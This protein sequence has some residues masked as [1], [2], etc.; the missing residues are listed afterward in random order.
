MDTKNRV[1]VMITGFAMATVIIGAVF[2]VMPPVIV[3]AVS[4]GDNFNHIGAGL[5][6]TVL[7][8]QNVKFNGTG[9][10]NA[11]SDPSKVKV[12]KFDKGHWY[13]YA[14]P[15][16]DGKAYN[17]DWG[18]WLTLRATDGAINTPL[19]VKNPY[20]PLKLKVKDKVV[21]SIA[22]GTANFW[23]DVSGINLLPEDRVDLVIIGPDGQIK[24]DS[25][26]NQI[27]TNITV[28]YLKQT[29]GNKSAGLNTAGWVIGDYTFQVKTKPEYTCGLDARSVQ[30][31]LKI[32][33]GEISIGADKTSCIENE[34]VR[35]TVKGVP[36]DS[37]TVSGPGSDVSFMD[38]VYDTPAS[39]SG[40]WIDRYYRFSDTIDEDGTRTYAVKFTDTGSYTIRVDVTSGA[41]KG[42]YDTADISVSE[43]A[44]VFDVPATV[45][46]GQKFTI[47]GHVNAGHFVTIAVED[48]VYNKL[49]HLVIDE[50][51]E[52]SQDIDTAADDIP[53]FKVP[54][55]VTLKAYIDR[56]KA[57]SYPDSIR[58]GERDDGST[59][60]LLTRGEL[61]A[62][63][64]ADNISRGDDF[65]ITGEA[66]GT[67]QV[68]I[69]II[70]PKGSSGSIIT[71]S[72][73]DRLVITQPDGTP[74]VETNI[75][76]ASVSVS[77]TD[78]TF[79]KKINVGA[80]A[81]NGSYL[82]IVLS[83]GSDNRYGKA[84]YDSIER[85]LG[86]YT[87]SGK[88]QD[89]VLA[90]VQDA[91]VG[92]VGSGDLMW[93]TYVRVGT[94]TVTLNPIATVT[95]GEPLVVTGT[96]N[97]GDGHT[98]II[99]VK[100]P[101]TVELTPQ[102]VRVE[103]GTFEATFD[104]T[105]AVAGI[106]TVI[107]DDGDGHTDEATVKILPAI[108]P[109]SIRLYKKWNF[110]SVPKKLAEGHNTFEQV[111]GSVDTAGH[112]IF[113]YNTTEGWRAV[114]A[115][116]EV[117]PL[118]GYWIYSAEDTIVNLTYDTY[119]LRTPPTRQLYK[120]W[121]A[122]GFSDTTPAAANSAL[123]SIERSWAY[124]IGFDAAKQGYESVII[125]DDETGG[126][127]DED[128][129]MYPMK[130]YWIY[131]TEDSELVGISV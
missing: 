6:E 16:T 88:T 68:D 41:R 69:L 126:S 72:S 7:E 15:W 92:A 103:N 48:K 46:I 102:L 110:I 96:S 124:L 91:T 120:G 58:S 27:F 21:T 18:T 45:V 74:I 113:Y 19:S 51:G 67:K 125:N 87:L 66:K 75:Y 31:S 23:L 55:S 83:P 94:P 1:K 5:Y 79:T 63:V 61:T 54:G 59:A 49:D 85:A 56:P 42:D 39:D 28:S 57:Y 77:E 116:E 112:S 101:G 117:K 37:I 12:E 14:G 105:N 52:F 114:S 3:M 10:P 73:A 111:F 4:T 78:Y 82:V 81:N 25:V 106:Y 100:G 20:I 43:K 127:H 80:E 119:P 22:A 2:A 50:N 107:A 60:I 47:K 40:K 108:T 118:R 24:Y 130:G 17:I 13:Y 9:E 89:E 129:L 30:K 95:V 38:G 8:G 29:Y 121:N 131:V 34:T 33:K 109:S 64:S 84:G 86:D 36:G 44:V 11:W 98:I 122:I 62:E 115:S 71:G 93:L 65:T 123:T 76:H 99:T 97:R 26:N 32:K 35:L 104:T 53:E 70:A 128:N 90:I